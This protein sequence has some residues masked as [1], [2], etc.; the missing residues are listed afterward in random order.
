M[1]ATP[2][3]APTPAPADAT[4]APT[5]RTRVARA[6]TD[7]MDPKNV[8]L[9]VCL[10]VGA[11][12]ENV[13]TGLGWALEAIVF[14]ALIPLAYIKRGIKAGD[15]EDRHVGQRARRMRLIPVIMAS[16]GA[17]VALMLWFD[18]PR[19]MIALVAAMLAT[20]AVILPITAAW[21]VSV[22]TAVSAGALA[23]LAV[24]YG[25]LTWIA[26]PLVAVIAWS[27]VALRDHTLAQT[28]VGALVGVAAAG[29]VFTW[30]SG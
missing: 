10:A 24:T 18:A 2:A 30:V 25:P 20:L 9:L 1:N 27:R 14:S 21:K 26:A 5:R 8:I 4:A 19:Q 15:W 23:M 11:A 22:H 3:P 6:V 16:V 29:A 17:G 7:G 28:V 13:L 12:Q